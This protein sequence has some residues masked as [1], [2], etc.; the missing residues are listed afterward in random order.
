MAFVIPSIQ[1]FKDYFFR[2]FPY[3]SNISWDITTSYLIGDHVFYEVN[4]LFYEAI[5]DGVGNVPTDTL[6]WKLFSDSQFNYI[7][8]LDIQKAFDEAVFNI[9]QGCFET[10]AEFNIAFFYIAAHYLVQDLLAS[11]Q[12]LNG[13]YS[14]LTTSKSVGNVSQSFGIPQH[15]LDSPQWSYLTSTRY[16]AKYLSIIYPCTIGGITSVEGATHP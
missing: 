7:L 4:S 3:L 1:D 15:I 11:S 13:S 12:G 5:A 14:W 16:G 10:Q 9:N 6:F 8:D 2:D